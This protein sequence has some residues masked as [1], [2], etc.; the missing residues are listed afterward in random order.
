VCPG[1]RDVIRLR[2]YE[3]VSAKNGAVKE[4]VHP[5][6]NFRFRVPLSAFDREDPAT[7][8]ARLPE[9]TV[10][11]KERTLNQHEWERLKLDAE[12]RRL[13]AGEGSEAAYNHRREKLVDA[14]SAAPKPKRQPRTGTEGCCG[15]GCNGCLI[16][17]HDPIFADAR[18]ALKQKKL[19]EMLSGEHRVPR[20]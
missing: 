11:R 6:Q 20:Q 16:F 1:E 13:E 5:G 15:K 19:G 3:F 18:A 17:T 8:M 7:L 12:A 2:L 10:V 9:L 4:A 14:M